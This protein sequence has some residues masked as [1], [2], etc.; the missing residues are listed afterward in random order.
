M[1]AD[2]AVS[3][4][5]RLRRHRAKIG[6]WVLEYVG[7]DETA[8]QYICHH[9]PSARAGEAPD[10]YCYHFLQAATSE[11]LSQPDQSS[12]PA[13]QCTICPE[14][15]RAI[16]LGTGRY[17]HVYDVCQKI[18]HHLAGRAV[19]LGRAGRVQRPSDAWL[20]LRAACVEYQPS[21]GAT[22]TVAL[23]GNRHTG[24]SVHGYG[25]CLAKAD[26]EMIG[27]D[28][29]AVHLGTGMAHRTEARLWWPTSLVATYP[30]LAS[31]L[32]TA[33]S[34]GIELS[35]VLDAHVRK[36]RDAADLA[37]AVESGVF[38]EDS[39]A[40]LTDY[41][42]GADNAYGMLDPHDLLGP[43]HCAEQSLL[44]DAIAVSHD[45]DSRWIL[46]VLPGE[47]F[48]SRATTTG[49]RTTTNKFTEQTTQVE[50]ACLQHLLDESNVR[51]ALLNPRLPA[52]QTQFCLRH[53]LEGTAD[54][55]QLLSACEF[56]E[57]SL[58]A[59]M[60]L[61]IRHSEGEYYPD[62]AEPCFFHGTRNVNLAS[63][64]RGNSRIEVVA[65][66]PSEQGYAQVRAVWPGQV[67]DFF[68]RH[69]SLRVRELFTETRNSPPQYVESP[70]TCR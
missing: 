9:W 56:A 58:L 6:R 38:P 52:A 11:H 70:S 57:P 18:L 59:A 23:L 66:D 14:N 45:A 32:A 19:R 44:T 36:C 34:E 24:K 12:V 43:D 40:A 41:L 20:L 17:A 4:G 65:F 42:S 37:R 21:A 62:R 49:V 61:A 3:A 1:L 47:E 68:S 8:H 10:A 28:L 39:F 5:S 60:R 53:Y 30:H 50:R 7:E 22:R 67:A 69:A 31:F 63:F 13:P 46:R 54:S 55:I 2:L 27:D 33:P 16:L 48:V 26:N 35:E 51:P 15:G 64:D 25:L 29:T